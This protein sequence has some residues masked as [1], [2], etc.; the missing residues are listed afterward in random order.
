[1]DSASIMTLKKWIEESNNIVAFTG[2]GCSTESGLPDF[3]SPGGIF[4][5]NG[6]I[7]TEMHPLVHHFA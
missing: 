7:S 1:M 4:G 6:G 5:T 2:A 3:R